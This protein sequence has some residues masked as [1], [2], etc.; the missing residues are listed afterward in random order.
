[1][2]VV[3]VAMLVPMRSSSSAGR[4]AI[5]STSYCSRYEQGNQY[6][7]NNCNE[8]NPPIETETHSN[9]A[10]DDI[11]VWNNTDVAIRTPYSNDE[12]IKKDHDPQEGGSS[13]KKKKKEKEK[14]YKSLGDI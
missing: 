8:G 4:A 2:C 3:F 13:K 11:D 7:C 9:Y 5:L 14:K 6:K 1:M 12:P 10:M